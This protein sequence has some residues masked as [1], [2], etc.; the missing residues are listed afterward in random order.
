MT[1]RAIWRCCASGHR[2]VIAGPVDPPW[3]FGGI[4]SL[5]G[6]DLPETVAA[7]DPLALTLA[8]RSLDRTPTEYTVFVHVV[9]PDGQLVAQ[10]DGPPLAGFAPTRI[11]R[12]GQ[13]LLDEHLVQLPDD[14]PP[15]EYEVRVGL[16]AQDGSRLPVTLGETAVGDYAALGMVQ[17]ENPSE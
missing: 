5:D 10:S 11:W 9:G 12:P 3:S 1:R 7:G 14:L 8:W 17:V 6:A 4:A 16:Y 13:T 2:P 15:G